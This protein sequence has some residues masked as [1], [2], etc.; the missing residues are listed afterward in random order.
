MK[1][2]IVTGGSGGIGEGL[3]HRLAAD[4]MQVVVHYGSNESAANEVVEAIQAGGGQAMAVSADVSNESDMKAL[5]A[6][7]TDRFGGV[8]VVVANAGIGGGGPI[9][10]YELDRFDQVVATNLRGAFLT[11]RE[12]AR[13]LRDQGRI[14]FVSSQLAGRPMQSSGVY[15]ATKAAMD[16]LVVSLSYE[17]GHRGIT[18][19]SVRPGA[20]V[21]GMF[22]KSDEERKDAFRQMSPFKRLGKPE[23][24]AAVVSFLSSEDGGWMTGQHLRADGGA[25]N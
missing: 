3:C 21:P 5:F 22:A 17:L 1:T 25:S 23:D 16:A 15:S 20:T 12:A 18:V 10:D 4:G 9:E 11:V 14:V 8:D 6:A 2:A 19:N 7:A 24:I 13:C